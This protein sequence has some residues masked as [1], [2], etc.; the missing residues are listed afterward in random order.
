MSVNSKKC[1]TKCK[2]Y[3]DIKDYNNDKSRKDGHHPWCKICS[4][5][6]AKERYR[7]GYSQLVLSKKREKYRLTHQPRTPLIQGDK[8]ICSNCKIMK[9]FDCFHSHNKTKSG[10]QPKCKLCRSIQAH[11][12][13]KIPSVKDRIRLRRLDPL[14]KKK[15]AESEKRRCR[16]PEVVSHNNAHARSRWASDLNYRLVRLL[17]ARV[18][19]AIKAQGFVKRA[20]AIGLLGCTIDEVWAH[21]ES[22]FPPVP[23]PVTGEMMT[24]ANHGRIWHIDH[25]RPCSSFDLS[26]HKQQMMCFNW[27]NLQAL[28]KK[29][30]LQ[31]HNRLDWEPEYVRKE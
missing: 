15:R 8:K 13:Y 3:K 30:N 26:D 14:V 23:C 21:L 19:S 17:R 4:S 31:K 16:R 10:L 2:I 12:R 18:K 27:T 22:T 25:I 1:C 6:D 20:K 5:N 11:A 7:G 28:Y 24:R 29:D 9:T